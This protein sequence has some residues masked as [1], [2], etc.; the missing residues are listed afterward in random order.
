[1]NESTDKPQVSQNPDED[2]AAKAPRVPPA[3]PV[4]PAV[5]AK[6][7]ADSMKWVAWI[8]AILG[9]VGGVIIGSQTTEYGEHPLAWYGVGV[10]AGSI[11][12]GVVI[13]GLSVVLSSLAAL[14][15]RNV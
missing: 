14:L 12:S 4:D 11:M 10:A 5:N 1:M 15:K 13:G 8:T 3:A 2:S 9:V 7:W 6:T